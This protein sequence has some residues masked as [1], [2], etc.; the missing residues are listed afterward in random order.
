[1]LDKWFKK[2]LEKIHSNHQLAV[3]IDESKEAKFLIEQL[4]DEFTIVS[5]KTE[6]EELK[7]KYEI[8]KGLP[9]KKVLIYTN[10]PKSNLKY[11]REYCETNGF[12]E[13]KYLDHY[14]KQKVSK[15]LNLNINLPKDE[16]ISAAKVSVGNEE[17]YWV[18]LS[19]KGAS[20]IFELERE[21]LP[22]LHDPK[23]HLSDY[24]KKVKEIFYKNLNELIGQDYVDKPAKTL[25]KEVAHYIFKSLLHNNISTSLLG[26]FESWLDSNTYRS[27]LDKYLREYKLERKFEVFD[28]H[29]SHPFLEIDEIWLK[30]LSEN[31]EDPD[32]TSSFLPKINRRIQSKA[33]RNLDVEFWKDVKILLE[34]D[35]KNINQLASLEECTNFYTKHFYKLDSAIRKLYTRFLNSESLIS[36]FQNYYKNFTDLFLNKWFKYID[37]YESNQTGTIHRLLEEATC[38]IAIIVGDGVS[39]E[40]AQ[41]IISSVSKEYTLN[42]GYNYMYAGLPSETE[43]NMS[44]LYVNTGEVLKSK[45]EREKFLDSNNREKKIQF[46]DLE[47]V[48]ENTDQ[49][50]LICS[51]KD[52]DK[53]GETYQQKALKH[54][55]VA[56][57]LYS[58]KIDQLFK[59]GYDEVFLVTDHGYVLTGI[60]ENSDKIEVNVSGVGKKSERYIRTEDSMAIDENLLHE[61]EITYQNFNYCYFAKRLGPFKTPGVYGFSHGGISPQETIIP[62]LKWTKA[63]GSESS[64]RVRIVNKDELQEIEGD[65]YAVKIQAEAD[66]IDLFNSQR[67]LILLFFHNGRQINK[68]DIFNIEKGKSIKKEFSFGSENE[69]EM[70]VLDAQTKEQLDKVTIK[71]NSSRNLGGLL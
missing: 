3:F 62:F 7:V 27:S 14:I 18:D 53:L 70:K 41:D 23:N 20:E 59:N 52:P 33:A 26:I 21:L 24:D 13:I 56:V 65:I 4:D 64:L 61:E 17:S 19:H 5:P 37:S 29:P 44:Q 11:I 45:S 46:I 8:E 71:K 66:S 9:Q 39:Y 28:V 48:N 54:F 40:F 42:K 25:A 2:D 68:S 10:T 55:D 16:L 30:D 31:L 58:S 67:K 60:L 47:S 35:E 38:K 6:L 49:Q 51:C 36:P 1:M 22:F 15:H 43:H 12:I 57:E 50:Y 69:I 34:F 63:K 32:Y